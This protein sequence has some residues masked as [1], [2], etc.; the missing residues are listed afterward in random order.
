M[1]QSEILKKKLEA[2]DAEYEARV[3]SDVYNR[4]DHTFETHDRL[5]REFWNSYGCK[6]WRERDIAHNAYLIAKR[7][8]DRG[9]RDE[10]PAEIDAA[11]R[12]AAKRAGDASHALNQFESHDWS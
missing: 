11:Y 9:E 1:K 6:S 2:L 7:E 3:Q 4:P 8:R 12:A 10:I 5:W